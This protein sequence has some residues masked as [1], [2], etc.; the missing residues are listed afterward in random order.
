MEASEHVIQSAA[1]NLGSADVFAVA[2]AGIVQRP[3]CGRPA[4]L[5]LGAITVK[6]VKAAPQ[7]GAAED[8]FA[9]FGWQGITVRVPADWTLGA[10]G[11]DYKQGYARLD[12]PSMPRLEVKWSDQNVNLDRALDKYLAKLG[13]G[14]R[15]RKVQIDDKVR[16]LSRRSKPHKKLRGFSWSGRERAEGVIWRCD[17]CKRTVIAQVILAPGERDRALAR[18]ILSSLEDHGRDGLITWALYGLQFDAPDHLRLERQKLMAGYLE[19]AFAAGRRKLRVCRWGM[20]DVALADRDLQHWYEVDQVRRRD[21]VWD[22]EPEDVKGHDGLV[23]DGHRR[24][25]GHRPRRVVERLMRLRIASDFDGRVWHCPESNRIYAVESVHHEDLQSV[26]DVVE[27]VP[28]HGS[29]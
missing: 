12:D 24:R 25:F 27:S 2:R 19:L 10:I 28:C 7:S 11:G 23:V 1:W 6:T 5:R 16:I 8:A 21:V 3:Q 15:G 22:C 13:K 18:D 20:A 4:A 9:P 26:L 29:P 14:R 17:T